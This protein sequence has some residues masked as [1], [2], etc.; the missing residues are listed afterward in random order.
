MEKAIGSMMNV[1]P[2]V[3]MVVTD[4]LLVIA[5]LVFVGIIIVAMWRML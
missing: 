3:F 2:A 4:S 5:V 1:L